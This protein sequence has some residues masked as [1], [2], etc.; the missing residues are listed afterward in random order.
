MD[1]STRKTMQ[2]VEWIYNGSQINSEGF[3]AQQTGSI[4]SLI[5]DPEAIINNPLLRRDDDENWLVASNLVGQIK[6]PVEVVII[7]AVKA[8]EKPR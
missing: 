1:R 4:V 6:E 2:R 8:R 7:L 3:A 5:D